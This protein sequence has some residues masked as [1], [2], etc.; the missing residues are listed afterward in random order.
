MATVLIGSQADISPVAD[1]REL[2][3]LRWFTFPDAKEIIRTSNDKEKADLLI[4]SL[5][6]CLAD[7]S[8]HQS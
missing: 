2:L 1:G 3:E 5:E 6:V 7:I 8:G 4:S